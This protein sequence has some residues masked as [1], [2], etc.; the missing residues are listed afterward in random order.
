MAQRD[1][2]PRTTTAPAPGVDGGLAA[3]LTGVDGPASHGAPAEE[4]AFVIDGEAA[5][6]DGAVPIFAVSEHGVAEGR[7]CRGPSGRGRRGG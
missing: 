2:A 1:R 4:A 6:L 5:H 7:R 3:E